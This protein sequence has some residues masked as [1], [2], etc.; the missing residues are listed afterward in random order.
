MSKEQQQTA[1]IGLSQLKQSLEEHNI[2][3]FVNF[4]NK[5]HDRS[6]YLDNGWV[7]KIGRG[8]D[9]YQPTDSQFSVGTS[10]Y[11]LRPCLETNVDI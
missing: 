5:L 7:I 1:A 4:N 3:L 8:L 10:N 2:Q 9:I 11:E 6:I